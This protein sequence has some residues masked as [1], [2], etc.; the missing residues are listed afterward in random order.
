MQELMHQALELSQ[1]QL[2]MRDAQGNMLTTLGC[3]APLTCASRLHAH[4][5]PCCVQHP[6]PL[7]P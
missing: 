7:Q 3:A 4:T 5:S 2:Q 1:H 6:M